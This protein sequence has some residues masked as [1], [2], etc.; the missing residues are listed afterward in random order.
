MSFDDMELALRKSGKYNL[1]GI[2]LLISGQVG[3][4]KNMI[5]N[6]EE[7]EKEKEKQVSKSFEG[8]DV[9]DK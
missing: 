7:K 5:Y 4:I 6:I 8:A 2:E 1:L 3:K 9:N